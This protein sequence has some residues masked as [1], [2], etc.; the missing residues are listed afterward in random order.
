MKKK[1]TL[2]KIEV[3]KIDEHEILA[4]SGNTYYGDEGDIM[5]ET[6]FGWF[7]RPLGGR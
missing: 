1:Y 4:T 2:A 6:G 5:A 7:D 3:I